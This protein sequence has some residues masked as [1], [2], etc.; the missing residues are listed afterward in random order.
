MSRLRR[1][2]L[3]LIAAAPHGK[4]RNGY[5]AREKFNISTN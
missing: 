4:S 3:A 1:A 5:N 2:G